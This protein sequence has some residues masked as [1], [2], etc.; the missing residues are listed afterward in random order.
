MEAHQQIPYLREAVVFLVATVAIVPLFQRLRASPV[1][2]YLAIGALIGPRGLGRL[3]ESHPWLGHFVIAD[4]ELVRRFAELGI[5]LLLFVIG[6]GLSVERVW[7]MRR[8]VF[9]LGLAQVLACGGAIGGAAW[10]LGIEP[11]AATVLGACLALSSTAV[12]VQL[13]SERGETA[14]R[15]GRAAIAVL[16]FQDLAV[17]PI[18]FL[19]GVLG[20]DGAH[21]VL[22]ELGIALARAILAVAL[23][24]ALGR[25]LLRPVFRRIAA[26][27]S[28]GLFV[29]LSLLA[30]IGT[31]WLTGLAGLSMA[32]GAFLAGLVL[33]ETEF[34]HQIEMEIA[35]F[36]ELLLSLFF[37]SV[38]MSIDLLEM[39]AQFLPLV[40]AVIGLF[41]V[42]TLVIAGL[43]RAFRL[44]AHVALPL[45]LLLGQ[46]GEFG[47][48][49]VGLATV[50]GVM[51]AETGRFAAMAV[52]LTMALTPFAALLAR[53]AERRLRRR[54]HHHDS[55]EPPEDLGDLDGHVVIAGMGRVG[56]V[57]AMALEARQMPYVAVDLD[58]VEVARQRKQGRPVYFGDAAR[59]ELL[60][61]LGLERAAALVITLDAADVACRVL[62]SLRDD[63]PDLKIY[64]RARDT[65]HARLLLDNGATQVVPETVE[66]SL[67]LAEHVL[68]DLGVP[69]DAADEL[70]DAL[71]G[72]ILAAVKEDAKERVP[73]A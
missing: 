9:G 5:V 56:G 71:R 55:P 24:L 32:L 57:V 35:P 44:P 30:V 39:A 51:P 22:P 62:A 6:L 73:R 41:A 31:G 7:T 27:R 52:A 65:D 72:E 17:V 43:G 46:G 53:A 42:K 12:V 15:L 16:L 38:G 19:V 21:G 4:A 48:A 33:A 25:L 58:A 36:K 63:W 70:V 28:Q 13:L 64:A 59:H 40:L 34:R 60:A 20:G 3:A 69:R 14:T 49:I 54:V 29:A 61:R 47:F 66:A 67:Q 26:L 50:T 23:I 45:G 18:L 37:V 68:E 10:G 1:L 11:P 8:A 2:G